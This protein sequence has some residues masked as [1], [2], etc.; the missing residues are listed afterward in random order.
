MGGRDIFEEVL[1]A[2]GGLAVG[3]QLSLTQADGDLVSLKE[4]LGEV[5]AEDIKT[6]LHAH[7]EDPSLHNFIKIIFRGSP[8]SED[9]ALERRL[10]V[11]HEVFA[12]AEAGSQLRRELVFN[13]LLVEVANLPPNVLASLVE[14]ALASIDG[15]RTIVTNAE[16]RW[17]P[18]EFLPALLV[19]TFDLPPA[20]VDPRGL[21]SEDYSQISGRE[22][23]LHIIH[24]VCRRPWP[25]NAAT[26]IVA[27]LQEMAGHFSEDTVAEIVRKGMHQIKRTTYADLPRLAHRL[28]LMLT[29]TSVKPAR[30]V[31]A[32]DELIAV[33]EDLNARYR[34]SD[35]DDD[36][37]DGLKSSS[38]LRIPGLDDRCEVIPPTEAGN[39]QEEE[40]EEEETSRVLSEEQREAFKSLLQAEGAVVSHFCMTVAKHL[41]LGRTFV[42]SCMHSQNGVVQLTPLRVAFLLGLAKIKRL[43]APVVSVF[44]ARVHAA[45]SSVVRAAASPWL[46]AWHRAG[47]EAYNDDA[48]G[49]AEFWRAHSDGMFEVFDAVIDFSVRGGWDAVVQSLALV[50]VQLIDKANKYRPAQRVA[51]DVRQA[52]HETLFPVRERVVLESR[53]PTLVLGELGVRILSQSFAKHSIVQ[54]EVL[55]CIKMRLASAAGSVA[56]QG[57]VQVVRLLALLVDQV[58]ELILRE[59]NSL[60]DML[61]GLPRVSPRTAAGIL[62]AVQ[63]LFEIRADMVDF[64]VLVFRKALF[65]RDLQPRLVAVHGLLVLLRCCPPEQQT[66]IIN[67]VRRCL[68]HQMQ[69]RAALYAGLGAA[70]LDAS[71]KPLVQEMLCAHLESMLAR[72]LSDDDAAGDEGGEAQG[73]SANDATQP[74]VKQD[75]ATDE[76]DAPTQPKRGSSEDNIQSSACFPI[77]IPERCV[78]RTSGAVLDPVH[79]LLETLVMTGATRSVNEVYERVCVHSGEWAGSIVD[80]SRQLAVQVC[81]VLL[82]YRYDERLWIVMCKLMDAG[83]SSPSSKKRNKHSAGDEGDADAEPEDENSHEAQVDLPLASRVAEALRVDQV[84]DLI[85]RDNQVSPVRRFAQSSL[86]AGLRRIRETRKISAQEAQERV[87]GTAVEVCY[88][89]AR[90]GAGE[91]PASTQALVRRAGR[92]LAP[93]LCCVEMRKENVSVFLGFQESLEM[94]LEL[95]DEEGFLRETLLRDPT[96]EDAGEDG[97]GRDT[98]GRST[99]DAALDI[100]RSEVLDRLLG[101]GNMPRLQ[102]GLSMLAALLPLSHDLTEHVSWIRVNLIEREF[103]KAKFCEAAMQVHLVAEQLASSDRHDL[104]GTASLAWE[105]LRKL[106]KR[107]DLAEEEEEE[108]DSDA[109]SDGEQG[110]ETVHVSRLQGQDDNDDLDDQDEDDDASEDEDNEMSCDEDEDEDEDEGEVEHGSQGDGNDNEDDDDDDDEETKRSGKKKYDKNNKKKDRKEK[111]KKKKK[112]EKKAQSVSAQTTQLSATQAK[113]VQV[114]YMIVSERTMGAAVQCVLSHLLAALEECEWAAS[115]MKEDPITVPAATNFRHRELAQARRRRREQTKLLHE[116]LRQ[117]QVG[118]APLN[119]AELPDHKCYDVLFKAQTRMYKVLGAQL[120]VRVSQKDA[121]APLDLRRLLRRTRMNSEL[122]YKTLRHRG[123]ATST[124]AAHIAKEAKQMPM[125]VFQ[126]EQYDVQLVRLARLQRSNA[127]VSLTDF[128]YNI[129][130]WDFQIRVADKSKKRSRAAKSESQRSRSDKENTQQSSSSGATEASAQGTKRIKRKAKKASSSSSSSSSAAAEGAGTQ[131]S[132]ASSAAS[133][134]AA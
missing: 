42:K 132:S 2:R 13:F 114:E 133:S 67:C 79:T 39:D 25:V 43:E 90:L 37:D 33:L 3:S 111:K 47:Q 36:D 31:E 19:R 85:E 68:G 55:E 109:E 104:M 94:A 22:Y 61:A 121:S 131:G 107:E 117:I 20:G 53:D 76:A 52:G 125:L 60:K 4:R 108:K 27:T 82:H 32:V 110:E 23:A 51:R 95:G 99:V 5:T 80:T 29:S 40:E 58:P 74:K 9:A 54:R 16:N 64:C 30:Q 113:V 88:D 115:Q 83:A 15:D 65:Q 84:L 120:G 96:G 81:E 106:G 118:W 41:S 45:S 130:A 116:K 50:G 11:Y 102:A 63:P 56:D 86:A 128:V 17:S 77:M 92:A 18:F 78:D 75:A 28:L 10:V 59:M 122:T 89:A 91:V 100:V 24:E 12:L 126:I 48:H 35:D 49:D 134:A 112:K 127:S 46:A 1:Q 103:R 14:K 21:C 98:H 26:M 124:S 8:V 73:E 97:A 6:T 62:L 101:T 38:S 34:P 93:C 69:V 66:E 70:K 44:V 129:N 123:G 72:P 7:T 71:L 119:R 57:V 105:L 87:A